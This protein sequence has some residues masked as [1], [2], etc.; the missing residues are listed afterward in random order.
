[1]PAPKSGNKRVRGEGSIRERRRT[2]EGTWYQIRWESGSGAERVYHSETIGPCT[3]TEAAARLREHILERDRLRSQGVIQQPKL[4]VGEWLLRWLHETARHN[5]RPRTY[6]AYEGIVR[7]K[8]VPALGQIRLRDLGVAEVQSYINHRRDLGDGARWIQHQRTVL[9]AALTEAERQGLVSRNVARLVRVPTEAREEVKPLSPDDARA[10]LEAM[11]GDRLEALYATSMALGLRQSEALGLTWADVDLDGATLTVRRSLQRYDHAYHLD[12]VKTVRS[13]RTL[14]LPL[15]LVATLRAHRD[16]QAF[17]RADPAW[18]GWDAGDLVFCREDGYPL[19]GPVVTKTFQERLVD[20]GLPRV[21][22]H[23]LRH[24]AATY[25]LA[26]GV[27]MRVVMEQLGH[28]Q[29]ATTSDLYSH[30]LPE[31]QRDASER[32]AKVLF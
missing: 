17:E 21:R 2:R 28:S 9:R 3:K 10:F 30:V 13:R 20:L 16:R 25:L 5:V 12:P 26:A 27:S 4:S 18:Q 6:S 24:G 7:N 15:P 8:L 11:R 29:M 23:D 32:M 22:F 1:M 31:A 19:S 14:H